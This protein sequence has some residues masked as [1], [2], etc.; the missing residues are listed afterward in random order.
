MPC[1]CPNAGIS[2]GS[3]GGISPGA[4]MR[5]WFGIKGMAAIAIFPSSGCLF[6]DLWDIESSAHLSNPSVNPGPRRASSPPAG[7]LG[8]TP[9]EQRL[10]LTVPFLTANV[11]RHLQ[12]RRRAKLAD[13]RAPRLLVS[14]RRPPLC[15]SLC[16]LKIGTTKTGGRGVGWFS[17]DLLKRFLWRFRYV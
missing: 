17:H 4:R 15:F 7:G 1:V 3:L 14:R 5:F 13:A 16:C 12:H 6:L 8:P 10:P 11:P 2:L 9:P